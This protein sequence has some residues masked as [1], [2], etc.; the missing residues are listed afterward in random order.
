MYNYIERLFNKY[1]SDTHIKIQALKAPLT[2]EKRCL[3][4]H[5]LMGALW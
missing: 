5:I 3:E 2:V 4:V 1:F